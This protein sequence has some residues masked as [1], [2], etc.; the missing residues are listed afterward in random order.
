MYY[1]FMYYKIYCWL[2]NGIEPYYPQVSS[3]MILTLLPLSNLYVI[4]EILNYFGVYQ[5]SGSYIN[6]ATTVIII[7]VL[8]SLFV[9][10]QLYFFWINKWREI[11]VFFNDKNISSKINLSINFYILFSISSYVLLYIFDSVKA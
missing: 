2:K 11:I 1:K 4:L 5:F 6:S 8:L 9:F 7:T 3:V 10:N